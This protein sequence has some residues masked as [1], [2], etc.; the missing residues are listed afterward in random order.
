[1]PRT[2]IVTRDD[3]SRPH[4]EAFIK[5]IYR[6]HYK[7]HVEDFPS[8]LIAFRGDGGEVLCAA[9][10]RTAHLD[11]TRRPLACNVHWFA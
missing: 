10:L 11:C 8:Q 7:A 4:I 6:L 2:A 9:G 3:P 1:M 5:R